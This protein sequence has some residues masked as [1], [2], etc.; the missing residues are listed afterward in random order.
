M[1]LY[2]WVPTN[3]KSYLNSSPVSN[4]NRSYQKTSSN[5]VLFANSS[6]IAGL[7]E[8]INHKFD[9]MYAKRAFVHWYMGFMEEAEFSEAREDL[10]ALEKDFEEWG[11]CEYVEGEYDE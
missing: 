7:F 3:F 11:C 4:W 1:N 8:S 5:A 9:L 6:S 10:A 2:D